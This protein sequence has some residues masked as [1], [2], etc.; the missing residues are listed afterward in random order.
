MAAARSS[1]VWKY[2][3]ENDGEAAECTI[4]H[5]SVKRDVGNTSNLRRH[6]HNRHPEKHAELMK[7]EAVKKTEEESA[8]TVN[9]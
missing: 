7:L 3:V 1:L 4:C 6:L 5:K 9:F 2:F 8:E